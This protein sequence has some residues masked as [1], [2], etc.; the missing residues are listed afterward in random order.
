[1]RH[2]ANKRSTLLT[3]AIIGLPGH[4]VKDVTL[5]NISIVYGGIGTTAQPG[6]PDLDSLGKVPE[7]TSNYPEISSFGTLPAWGFYCRHAEGI[8]FENVTLRVEGTD[9]RPALVCDD[10][11]NMV[12]D[13]FH[14]L[15]TGA[16][17]VIVLNN[18]KGAKISNSAVPAG[19]SR[20][21]ETMGKTRDVEG[22]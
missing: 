4:P 21:L 22:P 16:E 13:G 8:R 2:G 17:P 7:R 14:V 11:R 1:V 10:A 9:Y 19:A 5:Q 20:F 3:A 15:S 18:V 12:L 6:Q